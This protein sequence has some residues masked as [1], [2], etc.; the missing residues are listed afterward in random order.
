MDLDGKP[1]ASPT[2][3]LSSLS[4]ISPGTTTN[5][6]STSTAGKSTRRP[7]SREE[8][9]RLV[10]D[11]V[12]HGYGSQLYREV[13]EAVDEAALTCLQRM[14]NVAPGCVSI[15]GGEG[16]NGVGVGI[17]GCG[18][19]GGVV[20]FVPTDA[21]ASKHDALNPEAH[22]T[23]DA[24]LAQIHAVCGSY[25]EYLRC[26]RSVF[27]HLDRRFVYLPGAGGNWKR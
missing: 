17:G 8:L 3:A 27:L 22:T 6:A 24:I 9:Y 15:G 23:S 25:Y 18:G 26:V 1:S 12:T 13:L 2:S 10:E 4:S 14:V 20:M 21:A 16:G 19:G 11:L 5:F 7:M